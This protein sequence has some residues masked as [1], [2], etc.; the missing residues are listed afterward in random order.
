MLIS[1]VKLD[2]TLYSINYGI[3]NLGIISY[4]MHGRSST[5]FDKY[6]G[7]PKSPYM[8]VHMCRA[9]ILAATNCVHELLLKYTAI[10]WQCCQ[11]IYHKFRK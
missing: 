1:Y 10:S 11:N 6:Y 5:K 3:M 8:G 2:H 9:R 4:Y 7:Y